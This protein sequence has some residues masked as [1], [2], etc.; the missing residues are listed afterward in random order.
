MTNEGLLPMVAGNGTDWG[1]P[2][3]P[4]H[5][6]TVI[7]LER[8]GLLLRQWSLHLRGQSSHVDSIMEK[9]DIKIPD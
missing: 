7:V 4:F 5:M 9:E 8:P 2:W 3:Q 6:E 1:F